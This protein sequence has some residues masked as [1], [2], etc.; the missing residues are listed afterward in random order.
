MRLG[1]EMYPAQRSL[2]LVERD[3]ALRNCGIQSMLLEFVL[4]PRPR[5]KAALVMHWL[6]G[7][8]KDAS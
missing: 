1:L 6:K 5:K 4:A 2:F 8:F 3:I 7:D